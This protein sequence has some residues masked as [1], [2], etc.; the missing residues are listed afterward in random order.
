MMALL[1]EHLEPPNYEGEGKGEETDSDDD[2][3]EKGA[4][5]ADAILLKGKAQNLLK[6]DIGKEVVEK[7]AQ[8]E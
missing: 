2:D 1:N 6:T 3:P 7:F 8:E 5:L 4:M